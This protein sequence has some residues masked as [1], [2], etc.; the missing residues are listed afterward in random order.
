[1]IIEPNNRLLFIGDSIT[2]CNRERPVGEDKGD[3]L[4]N[5]YVSLVHALITAV[6]P[7]M[8]IQIVNMG[9]GGNT[10][11]DL[12]ARW[13]SDVLNLSP[14]WLSIMIGIND[15]WRQ[16]DSPLQ[17]EYHVL[18][19]EYTTTFERFLQTTLPRL[20]GLVLMTP[21][22]IEPNPSEPMRGM[23]DRY[24]DVVRQLADKY[25]CVLVDKQEAMDAVL[26]HVHPMTLAGDRVHPGLSGHMILALAFV[27]ALGMIL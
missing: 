17:T 5:G 22:L 9:I 15:V 7:W 13:Q 10:I 25:Q 12:D 3:G 27:K 16:I 14:D 20:K 18:I 24:S 21:Y 11:R 19:D 2:D 4:G 6:T 26:R 23:M 1:M 8:N